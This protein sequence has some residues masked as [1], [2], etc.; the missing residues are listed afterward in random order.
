M[1]GSRP[2]KAL[3]RFA[4][5]AATRSGTPPFTIRRSTFAVLQFFIVSSLFFVL[6]A[7][8]VTAQT[9]AAD[10]RVKFEARVH[11]IASKVDGVVGYAI[12][13]L[14]SGERIAH[15]EHATFPTA[16]AIKL[17]IVYELFKQAEEG[18][19]RLDDT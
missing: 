4:R 5:R 16:S 14:T 2:R 18:T 7:R 8:S 12:V 9:P 3:A 11:E 17:A 19:L 1:M 6:S 10:L 13:D 15:L